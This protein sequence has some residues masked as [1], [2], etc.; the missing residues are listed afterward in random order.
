[1][2]VVRFATIIKDLLKTSIFF[3]DIHDYM[4]TWLHGRGMN[5][6]IEGLVPGLLII[7]QDQAPM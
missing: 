3:L 1:M 2:S 7:Q 6:F 4:A 5:A